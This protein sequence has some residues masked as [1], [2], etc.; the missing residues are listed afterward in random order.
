MLM[1]ALYENRHASY[2]EFSKYRTI[3]EINQE[4]VL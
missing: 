3:A 4:I 1:Y 2:S